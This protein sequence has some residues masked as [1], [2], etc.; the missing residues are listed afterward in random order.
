MIGIVFDLSADLQS[1]RDRF[2]ITKRRR[3]HVSPEDRATVFLL[4]RLKLLKI[5][6]LVRVSVRRVYFALNSSCPYKDDF[7]LAYAY[8]S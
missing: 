6:A 2:L 4:I 3:M 7:A 5:A 1:D 8:L